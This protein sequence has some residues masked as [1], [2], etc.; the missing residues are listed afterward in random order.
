M[1][2][3]PELLDEIVGH[4]PPG[5]KR[6]LRN[7]SLVAK[8][9]VYPSR[10]HLFHTLWMETYSESWLRSI[11][12]TNAE[13]L[14]HVRSLTCR[15]PQAPNSPRITTDPMNFLHNYSPSLRQL[16]RLTLT[17]GSLGSLAQIGTPSAFKHTLSYLCLWMCTIKVSTIVTLV[18]Y[19]PNL[20][21]L[22]LNGPTHDEADDQPIPPLSRPL[23]K[24]TAT[25][26]RNDSYLGLVD[27]LMRQRPQCD[28]VT[29]KAYSLMSNSLP[30]RI[31]DGVEA[32]IK[33][34]NLT[35]RLLGM[36]TISKV[37]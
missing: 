23:Q 36:R 16:E 37:L 35:V 3:P 21:H 2:L 7:C 20:A 19:Y 14:Q 11:S 29:I 13:V 5:D 15:T 24:L 31:I 12:Q 18:N 10:R 25:D 9:W 22:E 17:V 8:S 28:E 1:D 4:I 33:R 30:Q 26:L 32:S 6:S 27:Q 34:L